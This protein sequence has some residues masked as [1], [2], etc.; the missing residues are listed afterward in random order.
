MQFSLAAVSV[1]MGYYKNIIII[2]IIIMQ[3]NGY[4]ISYDILVEKI[5]IQIYRNHCDYLQ[6][7]STTK[8]FEFVQ[9]ILW[10]TVS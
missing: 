10:M 1:T 8:M 5:Y 3:K 4:D 7:T 9:C 2:I 6:Q